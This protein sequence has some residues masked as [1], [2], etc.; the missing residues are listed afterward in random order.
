[1]SETFSEDS[2]FNSEEVEDDPIA[3]FNVFSNLKKMSWVECFFLLFL[4]TE[5]T[6]LS[7]Y[8]PVSLTESFKQPWSKFLSESKFL[9]LGNFIP[10][11]EF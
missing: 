7:C 10:S 9:L 3:V 5:S 1:M 2:V 11:E 4:E 6:W 8:Q